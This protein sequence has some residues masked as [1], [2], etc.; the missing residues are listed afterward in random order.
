MDKKQIKYKITTQKALK[1]DTFKEFI[2]YIFDTLPE[3]Q[4]EIVCNS[5]IGNLGK[6]I[7]ILTRVLHVLNTKKL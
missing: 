1:P 6:N 3:K 4:A 2:K 5:F 7:L